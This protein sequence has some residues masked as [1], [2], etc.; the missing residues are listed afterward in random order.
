MC[1]LL[2][3]RCPV[4]ARFPH[5]SYHQD[6]V[7]N[8][9]DNASEVIPASAPNWRYDFG[10]AGFV[11]SWD[12]TQDANGNPNSGSLKVVISFNSALGGN[13][14]LAETR[15]G[16]YPGLNGADYSSLS[17]DIKID[18]NSAPDAFGNNGYFS[19]VIRNTDSYNYNQQFADNVR[20]A[21]SWRHVSVP[22]TGP[23]DHIRAL[24]WQL[25]GGPGQNIDGDVTLYLDNI[26][27]TAVPEPSTLAL[28]GLGLLGLLAVR[29]RY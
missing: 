9:F 6:V 21:D 28:V 15:D 23:Y 20:S 17:F 22:L 27:F 19:M 16:W 1:H 8:A 7:V 26:V 24:T 18:P 5:G 13:N 10:G 14:K 29:R 11:N 2:E 4:G 3:G 12:G 25:Y